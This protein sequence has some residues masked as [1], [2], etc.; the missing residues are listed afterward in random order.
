M[1]KFDYNKV[2]MY[3]NTL[4]ANP[5]FDEIKTLLNGNIEAAPQD[6]HIN[7][8]MIEF[9]EAILKSASTVF[10]PRITNRNKPKGK[11]KN[12]KTSNIWYTNQC[13]TSKT[14]LQIATKQM[15]KKPHDRQSI[16]TY[17]R[18]RNEYKRVCRQAEKRHRDRMV[19]KLIAVESNNPKQFWEII[20]KMKEYGKESQ[21]PYHLRHGHHISK[22]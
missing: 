7:K 19:N 21:D 6:D 11:T 3:Q 9:N 10:P 15:S 17:R 5:K 14:R 16:D 4:K 20:K 12:N 8:C 2:N 13:K 1:Y 18:A 22:S